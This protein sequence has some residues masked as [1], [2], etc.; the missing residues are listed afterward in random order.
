MAQVISPVICPHCSRAASQSAVYCPAC[1]NPINGPALPTPAPLQA[2]PSGMHVIC[3]AP[4]YNTIHDEPDA[5][6]RYCKIAFG[7]WGWLVCLMI[8]PAA[9]WLL[10]ALFFS[11]WNWRDVPNLPGVIVLAVA[12]IAVN[13]FILCMCVGG[14]LRLIRDAMHY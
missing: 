12:V 14:I 7:I 2:I 1:G 11:S 4:R 3:V 6:W 13:V 8:A 10:S 5:F 9:I